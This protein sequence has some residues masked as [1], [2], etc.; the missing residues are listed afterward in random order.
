MRLS[1]FDL[2]DRIAIVTGSGRG[3]GK[4]I[5]LEMAEAGAHIV[6][7]ARTVSEIE[8]TAAEV[9]AKGRK[10]IAVPADVRV[11]EQ[12]DTVVQKTLDEFGRIDILVN[13]AGGSRPKPA[14]EMSERAWTTIITENLTTVFLCSKAVAK[15]MVEQKKG[16][17]IN[18][19]SGA[20]RG[21]SPNMSAYGA[22]KAGIINLTASLASEWAPY[23]VRVNCVAPGAVL[24][25]GGIDSLWPNEQERQERV[26]R[27]ALG[28]FGTPEDIAWA[29]IYFASDASDWVTGQTLD[30]NGGPERRH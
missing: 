24:T 17:I 14:L 27:I 23:G 22:S 16:S 12:I 1:K 30:V 2:T 28:R 7:V 21:A 9:R 19:S 26:S 5:A 15:V 25:P 11:V 18:I 29:V 13:N 10:A 6:A 4:G 20:G 8:A 3:I